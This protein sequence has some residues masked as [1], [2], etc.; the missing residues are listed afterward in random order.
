MLLKECRNNM[1]EIK[2]SQAEKIEKMTKEI[3]VIFAPGENVEKMR[4]VKSLL[5]HEFRTIGLLASA[6]LNI[7]DSIG[8]LN[9][10]MGTTKGILDG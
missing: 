7:A 4:L 3:C 1:A 2:K 6:E 5:E 9:E 8:T 10:R